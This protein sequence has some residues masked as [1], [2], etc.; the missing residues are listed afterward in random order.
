MKAL[1]N[2][3]AKR[4]LGLRILVVLGAIATAP[5]FAQSWNITRAY[6]VD[7]L[8]PKETRKIAGGGTYL[9]GNHFNLSQI[10]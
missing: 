1:V 8:L 7:A 3:Q 9:F 4:Y 6:N 5:A 2:R 10:N